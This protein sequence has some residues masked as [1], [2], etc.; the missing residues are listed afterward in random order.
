MYH[1]I[2]LKVGK[3]FPFLIHCT[4]AK[5]SVSKFRFLETYPAHNTPIYNISWNTYVPSIFL[6][7]AAEWMIK[8][9]DHKSTKP[10]FMFDLNSQVGDVAWAPYS[11]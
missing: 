2:Q 11:R 10:L 3:H 1:G 5:I 4:L 6:T 8:I 7:C 9:W